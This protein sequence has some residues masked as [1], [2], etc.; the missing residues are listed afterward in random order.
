MDKAQ[1]AIEHAESHGRM[2]AEVLELR[3]DASRVLRPRVFRESPLRNF[4]HDALARFKEDFAT[5]PQ[6]TLTRRP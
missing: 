1:R 4:R 3:A 5:C 6:R 2:L